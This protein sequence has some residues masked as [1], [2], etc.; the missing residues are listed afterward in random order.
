GKFSMR[1]IEVEIAYR[2]DREFPPRADD[3]TRQEIEQGLT[4]LVGAEIVDTRFTSYDDT[5]PLERMADFLANGAYVEGPSR[6][7][8][9][10]FDLAQLEGYV[11]FDG[12][13]QARRVG[14]HPSRDPL[15]PAL[16]LVNRLRGSAGVSAG[17][18]VTT[19][20]YAGMSLAPLACSISAGFVGF[21]EV[22][23]SLR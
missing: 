8:W 10:E 12:R 6:A 22:A 20:S 11:A 21:G 7:D 13:D 19:G 3:Y 23:F 2:F 16:A 9:R 14:G 15:L 4:A 5:P 18:I 17:M 1:G